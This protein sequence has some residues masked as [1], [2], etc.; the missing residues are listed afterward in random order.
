MSRKPRDF[1]GSHWDTRRLRR[2]REAGWFRQ[3]EPEMIR[4]A[5]RRRTVATAA[6]SDWSADGPSRCPKCGSRKV[7]LRTRGGVRVGECDS[8]GWLFVDRGSLDR[9][10]AALG[11]ADQAPAGASRSGEGSSRSSSDR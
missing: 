5:I 11:K 10:V 8:C 2:V 1:D 4:E 3:H 7:T 6:A 9:L